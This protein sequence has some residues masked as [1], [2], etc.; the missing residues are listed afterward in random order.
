VLLPLDEEAHVMDGLREMLYLY[1]TSPS[2]VQMIL[3][4]MES[5]HHYKLLE[6]TSIEETQKNK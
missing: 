5:L 1:N 4:E 3:D 2:Y 6:E